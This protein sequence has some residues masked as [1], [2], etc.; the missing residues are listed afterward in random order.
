MLKPD[1][2]DTEPQIMISIQPPGN[3]SLGEA[4]SDNRL[5]ATAEAP[6]ESSLA[7][8][9]IEIGANGLSMSAT[10]TS[11]QTVPS[12]AVAAAPLDQASGG[13]TEIPNGFSLSPTEFFSQKYNQSGDQ[14]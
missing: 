7:G 14:Q 11:D 2:M 4:K 3:G 5:P 9:Q 6:N 12:D 8:G 13:E 10:I 1:P